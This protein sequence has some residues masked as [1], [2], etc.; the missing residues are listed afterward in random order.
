MA[1]ITFPSGHCRNVLVSYPR[2]ARWC[3][4]FSNIQTGKK[5][6]FI[7]CCQTNRETRSFWYLSGNAHFFNCC[8]QSS[9]LKCLQKTEKPL[10]TWWSEVELSVECGIYLGAYPKAIHH[11]SRGDTFRRKTW[12]QR[13]LWQKAGCVP[14]KEVWHHSESQVATSKTRLEILT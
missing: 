12:L 14:L 2:V 6:N 3:R 11:S 5:K 4:W 7:R 1:E 8:S 10:R 9:E 13:L